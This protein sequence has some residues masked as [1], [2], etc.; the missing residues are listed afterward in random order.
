MK[1]HKNKRQTKAIECPLDINV[2]VEAGAGTGKTRVIVKRVGYLTENGVDASAI[3]VLAFTKNA[4]QEINS[5]LSGGVQARTFSS[6]CLR[7]LRNYGYKYRGMKLFDV[8]KGEQQKLIQELSSQLKLNVSTTT[9]MNIISYSKNK[10]LSISKVVEKRFKYLVKQQPKVE[11]L[12]QQYE[13][14]KQQQG[15]WDFDDLLTEFYHCLKVDKQFMPKAQLTCQHLLVDEVQDMSVVQWKILRRLS[16]SGVLVFCVG[17]PAQ[18]IYQFRGASAKYLKKFKQKFNN[19]VRIKLNLNYRSSFELVALSNWL[20]SIVDPKYHLIKSEKGEA[21]LPELFQCLSLEKVSVSLAKNIG[22]LLLNGEEVNDIAVLVRTNKQ[23]LIIEQ[24]LLEA[25]IPIYDE[26][27]FGVRLMTTHKSKGK[28]FEAVF[29]I[30]PRFGN[31][32][33]DVKAAEQRILYV[34]LTRAKSKLTIYSC[35]NGNALYSDAVS[36]DRYPLDAIPDELTKFCI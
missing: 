13:S 19:S 11:A 5:R 21:S 7:A 15:L 12:S 28:E 2:L 25:K 27:K 9:L 1:N 31:V 10:S 22:Q 26:E 16:K 20:R 14:C 35:L 24:A 3:T 36:S 18:L 6:W 17:D 8:D 29:V 30:D 34:A 4:A 32:T 23:L 33:L